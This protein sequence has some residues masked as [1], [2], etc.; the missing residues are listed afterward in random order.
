MWSAGAC[1]LAST[2]AT[3]LALVPTATSM[4]P[5]TTPFALTDTVFV[6]YSPGPAIVRSV[7]VVLHPPNARFSGPLTIGGTFCKPSADDKLTLLRPVSTRLPPSHRNGS[8]QHAARRVRHGSRRRG[9]ASPPP[10]V[11]T[12]PTFP[13]PEPASTRQQRA[14]RARVLNSPLIACP[15]ASPTTAATTTTRRRRLTLSR[16]GTTTSTFISLR[17]GA[18][19]ARPPTED[20]RVLT[21]CPPHHNLFPTQPPPPPPRGRGARARGEALPPPPRPPPP[22]PPRR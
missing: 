5:L 1:R 15:R 21:P 19:C 2:R 13:T 4:L 12:P 7:C 11:R 9:E 14:G 6:W 17:A 18:H 8:L 20:A 10:P 3:A 22:P 16:S